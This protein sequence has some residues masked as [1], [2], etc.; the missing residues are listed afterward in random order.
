MRFVKG[1]SGKLLR[2]CTPGLKLHSSS[3]S[4]SVNRAWRA[5]N[6]RRA[7]RTI[8]ESRRG[9]RLP[10]RRCQ[11]SSSLFL[12]PHPYLAL[13]KADGIATLA[14]GVVEP[15]VAADGDAGVAGGTI[16]SARASGA[17]TL[18]AQQRHQVGILRPRLFLRREIN[19]FSHPFFSVW[20][21]VV[22]LAA[23][24]TLWY[25]FSP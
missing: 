25:N 22:P 9:V 13:D 15:L 23:R 4:P 7:M 18:G 2:F 21:D 6:R 20:I 10:C 1:C 19:K 11:P 3:R 8:C 17:L 16:L 14:F 5:A 24:G 12:K